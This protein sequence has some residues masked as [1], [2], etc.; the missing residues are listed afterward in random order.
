M[1]MK[2]VTDQTYPAGRIGLMSI[3]ITLLRWRASEIRQFR[4]KISLHNLPMV[5]SRFL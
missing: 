2:S 3:E 4:N 5:P 1:L